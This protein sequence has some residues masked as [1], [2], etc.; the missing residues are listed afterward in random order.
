MNPA[1]QAIDNARMEVCE[2]QA[3]L[4]RAEG[5]RGSAYIE[6]CRF[7]QDAAK[8]ARQFLQK[9]DEEIEAGL[10]SSEELRVESAE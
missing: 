10:V 8:R 6:F 5:L 1:L 4:V 3:R 7:A 9:M 2:C